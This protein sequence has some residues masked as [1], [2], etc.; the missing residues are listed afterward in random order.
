MTHLFNKLS[1]KSRHRINAIGSNRSGIGLLEA[2]VALLVLMIGIVSV[3]VLMLANTTAARVSRDQIIASNLA[4]ESVEIARSIRDS[5][6]LKIEGNEKHLDGSAYKWDDGLWDATNTLY[7]AYPTHDDTALTWSLVYTA[8]APGADVWKVYLDS[9][10]FPAGGLY[11]QYA[12]AVPAAATVTKYT[13][14]IYTYP[15]CYDAVGNESILN[16]DGQT[17]ALTGTTKIG[18][19]VKAQV[20]WVDN[21]N[22]RTVSVEAKLYNWK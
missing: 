4:R 8:A 21:G 2:M 12:G 6:W 20:R 3:M 15:I 13:R 17:C 9:T 14:K 16:A 18:V 7:G 22:N 11:N 19:Q 10:G 1:R 5:N